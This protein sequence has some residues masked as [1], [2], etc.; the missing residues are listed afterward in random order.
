MKYSLVG[1]VLV[2]GL[3]VPAVVEHGAEEGVPAGIGES[4]DGCFEDSAS[5]V[6]SHAV[7]LVS[8]DRV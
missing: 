4:C 6:Q 7:L 1:L 8:H 5:Y 2:V 3:E